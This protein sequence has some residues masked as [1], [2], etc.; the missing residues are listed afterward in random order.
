MI[1]DTKFSPAKIKLSLFFSVLPFL[2]GCLTAI[3]NPYS[4]YSNSKPEPIV[5]R[6]IT[7][8]TRTVKAGPLTILVEPFQPASDISKLGLRGVLITFQNSSQSE[9]FFFQEGDIVGIGGEKYLPYSYSDLL[10]LTQDYQTKKSAQQINIGTGSQLLQGLLYSVMPYGAGMGI[11]TATTLSGSAMAGTMYSDHSSQVMAPYREMG[12][13]LM[14]PFH[15][16]QRTSG[17][18]YFP[19]DVHSIEVTVKGS[20]IR[21]PIF[22]SKA[23]ITKEVAEPTPKISKAYAP[24]DSGIFHHRN[25]PKIAHLL[26]GKELIEFS[27]PEEV[28]RAGGRPCEVCQ[29]YFNNSQ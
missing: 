22:A 8:D 3:T 5:V 9:D 29:N 6:D 2:L 24:K 25:C 7:Q 21:I 26:V 18:L 11:A 23:P 16:S 1:A 14:F 15:A 13:A 4:H 19:S 12:K 27:S 10:T 17:V 28:L 20:P